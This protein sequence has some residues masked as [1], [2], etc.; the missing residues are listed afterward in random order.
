L[1]HLSLPLL[2]HL[3][4]LKE[5]SHTK[6]VEQ[7]I[8]FFQILGFNTL[9]DLH[10]FS[11]MAFKERWGEIGVQVWQRIQSRDE[12]IISPF[13]ALEPLQEYTYL[14][15]PLSVLSLLLHYTRQTAEVLFARLQGRRIFAQKLIL[16]LR[17][18]YSEAKYKIEVEPQTPSRDLDLFLTLLT[19]KLES[20]DLENPIR[21]FEIEVIPCTEKVRQLDFFEPRTTDHDRLEKLLCV[22]SQADIKSG[23]FSIQ[24]TIL[25]EKSWQLTHDSQ[26]SQTEL[27]INK[28]PR[29]TRLLKHAQMIN[30]AELAN[31]RLLSRNPL[32]RLESSWW[33][34]EEATQRDYY[35]AIHKTGSCLWVYKDLKNSRYFLHGYFD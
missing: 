34:K 12:Q 32:E 8:S 10:D 29:P 15:F 18:E 1:Q 2:L 27:T 19:Q 31:I 17:C 28:A 25:P 6:T 14:D 11:L 5:W 24:N 7:M 26:L 16:N 21:D 20:L 9:G 33:S 30:E 22:L 35:F 23:L 3:Q 4:G 13:L